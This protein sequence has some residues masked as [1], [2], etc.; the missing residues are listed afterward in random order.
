[1]KWEK[2]NLDVGTLP[3]GNRE[4]RGG[5]GGRFREWQVIQC[6]WHSGHTG[7]RDAEGCAGDLGRAQAF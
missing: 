2:G 3:T 5:G 7:S 6:H 4:W 1:M